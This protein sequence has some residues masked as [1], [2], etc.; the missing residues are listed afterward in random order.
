MTSDAIVANLPRPP[1][2]RLAFPLLIARLIGNP[3]AAWGTDFY[4]EP[5]IV[6]R[7]MGIETA[8]VMDPETIQA[9]LLADS[10]RYSKQPLYDDVLGDAIGGGL[11]SAEG[12]AWRWQR[13]LAAPLFR[14]EEM[15]GF[16]S[17]FAK[18][19]T[20]PL[21]RWKQATPGAVQPIDADM[22]SATLHALQDTVLGANLADDERE[23]IDRYGSTFLRESAWKLALT[24]LHMPRGTPHPGFLRMRR[25]GRELRAVAARVLASRRA[26]GREAQGKDLL[27][28]LIAAR[29][30]ATGEAMPDAL[31]VDN[32][33][34]FLMAGHETTAQALTWT[35]Y[36]LALFPEWQERARQEIRDVIGDGPIEPAQVAR[37]TLVEM[38]FQEAMRLYPPAPSLMRRALAEV[39]LGDTTVS[40]GSAVVIPI[41]AIHRHHLLWDDPLRFDPDRFSPEAK[42]TRHRC[43]YLPFSTGPRNCIGASFAMVEGRVI[44][45]T[46]L[47]QAKFAL[48]EGEIPVPFARVTL[49][50]KNG[51]KLKVTML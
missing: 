26:E 32:V 35:L 8:F 25:A 46:L 37:L 44:L 5:L 49:R 41:Y 29:D 21:Q 30:P 2:G 47:S 39:M 27:S 19:C 10:G 24:T 3:I 4:E 12:D 14:A 28:R 9:V 40:P 43:S 20:P 16:T 38:I 48:P 34:T 17:A 13:R 50:P 18:A 23:R 6:Y 1:S 11:L 31:I 42:A 51:L 7:W 36:L 15:L 45:A 22:A 33:V